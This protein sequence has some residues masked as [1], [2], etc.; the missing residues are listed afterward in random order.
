MMLA[1]VLLPLSDPQ[2]ATY[3]HWDVTTQ[4]CNRKECRGC[5]FCQVI[6]ETESAAKTA[7]AKE[8]RAAEDAALARDIATHPKRCERW[9]DNHAHWECTGANE[10]DDSCSG[11]N[12]CPSGH[13]YCRSSCTG[14]SIEECATLDCHA[15][16]FCRDGRAPFFLRSL[17]CPGASTQFRFCSSWCQDSLSACES[18]QCSLCDFCWSDAL[19]NEWRR[20]DHNVKDFLFNTRASDGTWPPQPPPP[21]SPS[22]TTLLFS[23]PSQNAWQT[24]SRSHGGGKEG[25]S[26]L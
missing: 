25:G 6:L 13:G 22:Y 15:C 11:C 7:A 19:L 24:I 23:T 14:D 16:A 8:I 2:C 17:P 20:A 5:A 10:L 18:C 4:G 26:H 3:C 9:C 21:P 12:W 1:V